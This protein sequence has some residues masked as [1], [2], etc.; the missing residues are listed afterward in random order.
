MYNKS[1]NVNTNNTVYKNKIS[2]LTLT[3]SLTLISLFFTGCNKVPANSNAIDST[4]TQNQNTDKKPNIVIFYVDDLGYG[5]IGSYGA[6]EVNTPNIDALANN[7]IRFT[8]A[9]SSSATC[10][11]SRYSLLTGEYAFRQNTAVLNGDA[12]LIIPTN[13]PTLP[14]MLKKAGYT[15]AVIGK[16]HL[17]LGDVKSSINWNKKVSPGP[18][19]VGFD[20]SF[21]IPA[22]GDRVPSV[23]LENHHVLNLTAND[24]IEVSYNNKIGNR[25]TGTENPELLRQGADEQHSNSII[26]GISRIGW[27]K[28]GTSAE[29]KDEDFYKIFTDMANFFIEDSIAEGSQQQPFFLFFSF[30]DIHVPRLPNSKFAGKSTLGVRGD[31]I[32]QMD[33]ITG[34]IVN[35]LKTKN[36]LEDTLIIFTS[37]N[38]PVLTD[39]YDDQAIEKLGNHTPAGK[40]RGGKYSAYEAGTRVPTIIHYP[41]KVNSG[42]SNALMSQIDIYA[43]LAKLVNIDLNQDEAIDSKNLL[44]AW[45]NA[46]KNGREEL[47]EESY[48][49]ALRTNQWKYIAP[50]QA[51]N[52]WIK[53]NKNI[54]SGLSTEP[55]L[56]NLA[57]DVSEQVNIAKQHP[58]KIAQFQQKINAIKAQ[59][60]RVK[61]LTVKVY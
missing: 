55:Q 47:I 3:V 59:S 40:F 35:Q 41:A 13:K 31:A 30:H 38:G 15:T 56:F 43:S 11:P 58:E 17:G 16:W 46:S 4:N 32:A 34:N 61:P 20:Y 52:N 7:G 23:Y 21:L 29:W 12:A 42:T 1:T 60:E 24:P 53:N 57:N 36:L 25:P 51:T 6:K 37:D 48:T 19:E 45:L 33:W 18:L 2:F 10:T 54:E 49:L 28:G 9:H 26:N 14:K 22:T 39:G 27:M 50:T 44:G 8:D 5:D